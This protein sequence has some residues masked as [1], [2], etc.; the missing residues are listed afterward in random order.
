MV[1]RRTSLLQ[2]TYLME[3]TT[4]TLVPGIPATGA[5]PSSASKLGGLADHP[6]FN[7]LTAISAASVYAAARAGAAVIAQRRRLSR[8]L[9]RASNR[10]AQVRR[11]RNGAPC[12]SVGRP[13]V[14]IGRTHV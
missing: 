7:R 1:Q 6:Q 10:N 13:A 2:L 12:M 3:R 9:P 14:E 5:L 8:N 11:E 4:S